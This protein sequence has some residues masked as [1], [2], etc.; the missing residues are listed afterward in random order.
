M[1]QTARAVTDQL[2]AGYDPALVKLYTEELART[3][4]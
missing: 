4:K 2:A 3:H 1:R